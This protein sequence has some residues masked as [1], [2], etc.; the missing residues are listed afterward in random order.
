MDVLAEGEDEES[1][2]A[3]VFEIK[4]RGEKNPPMMNDAELFAEKVKRIK[5]M[6]DIK[7]KKV[8][9]VCPV[10]LSAEG[11][12]EEVEL[13]LHTQGI[14]TADMKTWESKSF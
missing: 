1:S 2:W 9:F 12:A 6:L 8:S 14:F 7:G 5:E 4:N 13:W 10:Y 11:F 3:L